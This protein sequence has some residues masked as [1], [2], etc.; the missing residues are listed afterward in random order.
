MLQQNRAAFAG[1][2]RLI[3]QPAEE[4]EP[5]GGR[6]VVEEGLLD[7]VDAALGIH[8]DPELETGKIAMGAGAYT[9]AS[10]I[11]DV[12]VSGKSAHAAK[13]SDGVDAIIAACAMVSQLQTIVSREVEAFDPLVLSVTAIN[14]GTAYN[15]LA[16]QVTLKGTIRY[17]NRGTRDRLWKR[18]REVLEGIATAH[19]ATV[20][21]MITGGEPAV[22]NDAAMVKILASS[23]RRIF[24]ADSVVIA[25]GWTAA[26]DFGFYSEKRPSV[27]FRLGIRNEAEGTI[28]PL[29]HPRFKVDEAA[30]PIGA[31]ALFGAALDFLNSVD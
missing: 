13:P 22:I 9:L 3:F 18:M 27:Y 7:D 11:F 24:G 31:L 21:L 29:H 16:D 25:P 17:G 10:D 8:V 1:T 6:R 19:R 2:I 30:L 5:L 4:A 20:K 15:V 28:F 26:D 23:S 14:G 12:I